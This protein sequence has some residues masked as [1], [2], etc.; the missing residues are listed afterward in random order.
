MTQDVHFSDP[1]LQREMEQWKVKVDE[2]GEHKVGTSYVYLNAA[3]AT[4]RLNECNIGNRLLVLIIM[5]KIDCS[6]MALVLAG[7]QP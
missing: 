3:R 2:Y 4:C 6:G 7:G 5:L 1:A